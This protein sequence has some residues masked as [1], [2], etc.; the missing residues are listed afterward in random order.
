MKRFA[1]F[2]SLALLSASM[3][4]AGG[5][6]C[7]SRNSCATACESKCE[8]KC[9]TK[10]STRGRKTKNFCCVHVSDCLTAAKVQTTSL[11]AGSAAIGNLEVGNISASGNITFTPCGTT[12]LNAVGGYESCLRDI[13]GTLNVTAVQ[14]SGAGDNPVT[15]ATFA[16]QAGA[17]FAVGT[18]VVENSPLP[19]AIG[20]TVSQLTRIT[21]PITFTTAF[22]SL[23]TI[24]NGIESA[25]QT[26]P[27]GDTYVFSAI[28][29]ANATASGANLIVS[30]F[31]TGPTYADINNVVAALAAT[32]KFDFIA[33][34]QV[35]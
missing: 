3:V 32:L 33:Q 18:A 34:G 21:L 35:S 28:E 17:G 25:L 11:E 23:P 13:R 5:S 10:C 24:V 7:G 14:R 1:I 27:L 8:T 15:G 2:F 26:L 30:V 22:A 4:L 6:S 19:T 20:G 16:V 29:Q 31:A 9:D 12:V